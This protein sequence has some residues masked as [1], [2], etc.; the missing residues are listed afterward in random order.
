MTAT[1]SAEHVQ[2]LE[3]MTG[4]MVQPVEPFAGSD[5]LRADGRPKPEL[6]AALR[7]IANVRN[8]ATCFMELVMPVAVVAAVIGLNAWWAV[9]LAVPVMATLQLRMY[10]IHHEAAHRLLFSN[11]RLNDV[12]GINVMGWLPLGTGSHTYRRIHTAHHRDE[13]GPNEPD[14]LLYSFYPI[15][16]SSFARKL[17]RDASG[18]SAW[19]IIKPR[20][21]DLVVSGR[22]TMGLRLLVMQAAMFVAFAGAGAPWLYLWLWVVPYMTWYQVIN[23]LRSVAEHGGLTRSDD[24]RET[25]HIVAPSLLARLLIAPL[26]VGYHL[27]HHVDSGVPFRNLPRLQQILIEDGYVQDHIVWPSY[28]ALW[29]AAASPTD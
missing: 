11:R 2:L 6:R 17:R 10:I 29:Q 24:R 8:A 15:V 5:R 22:R 18:V 7:T 13:F 14:F 28:L 1:S 25:T 3:T 27:P 16:R 21:Q 26:N 9:G 20:L 4:A 12:I 23:R 19:R